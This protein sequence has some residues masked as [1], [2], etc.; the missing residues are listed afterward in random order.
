MYEISIQAMPK[1]KRRKIIKI[2]NEAFVKQSV[3]CPTCEHNC[4]DGCVAT[5]GYFRH[6]DGETHVQDLKS[7]FGW[8][9]VGDSHWKMPVEQRRHHDQGF[10][11]AGKGCRLP[12]EER[13]AICIG[14]TCMTMSTEQRKLS[15][16]ISDIWDDRAI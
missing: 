9:P 8:T 4:C 14:F 13:S 11:V 7:R 3:P 16:D 1:A 5:H 6:F 2:Y 15:F 10:F 12:V